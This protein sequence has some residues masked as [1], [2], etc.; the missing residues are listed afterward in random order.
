MD[1]AESMGTG[2]RK[3][4]LATIANGTKRIVPAPK[5]KIFYSNALSKMVAVRVGAGWYHE[6]RSCWCGS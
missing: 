6:V 1:G 2:R 3:L 4:L 5:H